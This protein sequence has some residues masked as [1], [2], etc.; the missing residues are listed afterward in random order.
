ML[1]ASMARFYFGSEA[2]AV[3]RVVRFPGP[4]KEPHQ[5]VGVINDFVRTTPRHTLDYFS[6]Y[7][8]YRHAD[9]INAGQQSRLRVMLIAIKTNKDNSE[10]ANFRTQMPEIFPN[11]KYEEFVALYNK[12][13]S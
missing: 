2:A 3:G 12:L 13:K 10:A 11:F 6:T 9:A 4:S 7:Y 1:N 5:I 8:P